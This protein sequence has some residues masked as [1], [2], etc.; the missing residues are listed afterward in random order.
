MHIFRNRLVLKLKNKMGYFVKL[1]RI[2]F[3]NAK[4][5]IK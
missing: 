2:S 1:K 4:S 5:Y 3:Y